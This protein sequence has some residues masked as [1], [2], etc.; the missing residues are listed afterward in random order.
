MSL[1]I[2]EQRCNSKFSST[3]VATSCCKTSDLQAAPTFHPSDNWTKF[4]SE[5][6]PYLHCLTAIYDH[7]V[8]TDL[9]KFRILSE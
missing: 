1:L 6:V 3:V 2:I 5:N 4:F 8:T 7:F 9:P